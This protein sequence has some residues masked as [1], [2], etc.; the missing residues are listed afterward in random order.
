M[1]PSD[2]HTTE[3]ILD[4]QVF[5]DGESIEMTNS[6]TRTF[7]DASIWINQR[8]VRDHVSIDPGQ[9]VR[10][11]LDDFRD[12]RGEGLNPGG[13]FRKFDPTPIRLTELQT[14]ETEPLVGLITIRK[15]PA[16]KNTPR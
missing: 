7:S 15:E 16:A 4:I 9:T 13:L 3:G 12:V 14:G 6:T 8:Y 2:L 1:Y 5:R 10:L 11:A